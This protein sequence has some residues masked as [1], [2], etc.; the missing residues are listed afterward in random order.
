[1]KN[2]KIII[3]IISIVLLLIIIGVIAIF[4]IP[5]F[6]YEE[7]PEVIDYCSNEV[8]LNKVD[9]NYEHNNVNY[10]VDRDDNRVNTSEKLLVKHENFQF[11][12]S[13][14][15]LTMENTKFISYKCDEARAFIIS[16]MTNNTGE[17]I[18][19]AQIYMKTIDENGEEINFLFE[20][21]PEI[22]NGETK[23]IKIPTY[24]RIIDAPD[25]IFAYYMPTGVVDEQP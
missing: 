14:S 25:F 15:G 1:M 24:T 20:D 23:E 18:K 22:L 4:A 10:I 13:K 8:E 7:K 16:T 11:R 5:Y 3:I 19:G 12:N 21:M 17:D 6:T 9:T 2:K